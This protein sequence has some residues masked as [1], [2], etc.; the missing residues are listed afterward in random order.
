[1]N[2]VFYPEMGIDVV[3]PLMGIPKVN[4]IYTLGPVPTKR[5]DNKQCVEKT[6]N[7]ISKLIEYGD[8]RFDHNLT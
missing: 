5:F 2:V 4:K 8:T 7:Y 1:M 3:A 6:M